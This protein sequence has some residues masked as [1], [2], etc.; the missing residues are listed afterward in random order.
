MSNTPNR[1]SNPAGKPRKKD[2]ALDLS[3][4]QQM[5]PLVKSIISDVV[6]SRQAIARLT[7]EQDRLERH[8]RD[9]VWLE[10]QRR[11]QVKDEIAAAEKTLTSAL[12]ELVGLGLNLVNEEAGEVD[13]PTKI[14]GRPAAF[15][16]KLGD[17]AL[18]N[19]HYKGEEQ[20]RPI[21]SDW[22]DSTSL[23]P[24]TP[25]RFRGQP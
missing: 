24:I 3:T 19:W 13:F 2:V 17:E 11:Y 15:T 25:I 10:R 5:L 21:P 16:W 18:R 12:T 4:A 6:N 9:L 20:L 7:P 8:R 1:A 22:D 23:T 14:N